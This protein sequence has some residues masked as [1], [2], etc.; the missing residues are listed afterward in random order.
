MG[1]HL[2][3]GKEHSSLPN[4]SAHFSLAWPISATADLLSKSPE[5]TISNQVSC[6]WATLLYK[7]S[8][9]DEIANVNFYDNIAHVE[10]SAY[11]H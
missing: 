1:T 7:N 6:F 2:P 8:S 4:F 3:H 11:A 9:G 10:A 5:V